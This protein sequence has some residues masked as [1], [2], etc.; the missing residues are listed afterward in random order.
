[1]INN[2]KLLNVPK[3]AQDY[4]TNKGTCED[5]Q[6][7]I[8]TLVEQFVTSTR[9]NCAHEWF[10]NQLQAYFGTWKAIKVNELYCP[11]AT[12][13]HNVSTPK[14]L[15][16]LGSLLLV[17]AKRGIFFHKSPTTIK[18]YSSIF[19][20]LIP[21]V[22]AGFKKYQ[23]IPYMSWDRSK[24]RLLESKQIAELYGIVDDWKEVQALGAEEL[25]RLRVDATTA[26]T[27]K[28]AGKPTNP[29]TCAKRFRLQFT[30]LVNLPPL[31]Q[32]MALQTWAAHPSSATKYT[33]L[34][35]TDW[36]AVPAPL[37]ETELFAKPAPDPKPKQKVQQE[38]DLPWD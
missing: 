34:D 30:P 11:E 37:I 4:L 7:L 35:P 33:I 13:K 26:L 38:T 5:E 14:D 22:L 1:M 20:P 9:L 27:G 12:Y 6:D 15:F 10:P 29:A 25:L 3:L 21:Q 24:I 8:D 18:Q 32:Y 23:D 31:A 28:Q 2:Y 19:N 36:D 16:A 17:K